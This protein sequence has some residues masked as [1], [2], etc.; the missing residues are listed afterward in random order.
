MKYN[1]QDST[2]WWLAERFK[3]KPGELLMPYI[4]GLKS[5]QA[6]RFDNMKRLNRAYESGPRGAAR[7]GDLDD[8]QISNKPVSFNHARR[9]IN[10]MH[11]KLIKSRI[12][13]TASTEGLG[14]LGRKNAKLVEKAVQGELRKN[15]FDSILHDVVMDGLLNGIGYAHVLHGRPTLEMEWAPADDVL[16]DPAETRYRKPRSIFR[17]VFMDKYVLLARYGQKNEDAYGSIDARVRAI[18]NARTATFA[19]GDTDEMKNLVEV[20]M[21][22]HLRSD[23]EVEDG[24]FIMAIDGGNDRDG[25]LEFAPWERDRLPIYWFVPCP[26]RRQLHG[27]AVMAD[28]LVQQEEH[29][30][31][32]ERIQKSNKLNGG[33]NLLIPREANVGPSKVTNAQGAMLEYDASQAGPGSIIEL[34]PSLAN[35][36]VFEYRRALIDEMYQAAGV[37]MMAATGQLPAGMQGASGRAIQEAEEES[38]EG[39]LVPHR[40]RDEFVLEMAW[41]CVEEAASIVEDDADYSVTFKNERKGL[42]RVKWKDALK[43]RDEFEFDIVSTNALAKSQAAR[44]AQLTELLKAGAIDVPTFRRLYGLPDLEAENDVDLSDQEVIDNTLDT[45][46][47]EGKPLLP[48]SFDYLQLALTRGR[49]FYN[50]CRNKDVPEDRLALLRDY[51]A[52]AQSLIQEQ[53]MKEMEMQAKAQMAAAPPPPQGAPMQ[54]PAP[55]QPPLTE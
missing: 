17:R 27:L 1:E 16:L 10:T 48:Q 37:P 24:K 11:A 25:T 30:N 35:P 42:E 15:K 6:Q 55:A 41:L 21:G 53:K 43:H 22:W 7:G 12:L 52:R 4:S 38:A 51:L 31:V 40:A 28:F 3:K 36:Q 50:M 8:D 26:R 54:A 39:L 13:P 29:D 45:I 47:I 18:R 2:A 23:P 44:F 9:G 14:P 19:L 32:T 34:K 49:K 46:V 33:T 20:W 5:K